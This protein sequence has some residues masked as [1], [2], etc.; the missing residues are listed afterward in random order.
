[1]DHTTGSQILQAIPQATLLNPEMM[2]TLSKHLFMNRSDNFHSPWPHWSHYT[3]ELATEPSIYRTAFNDFHGLVVSVTK[4]LVQTTLMQTTSRL[5][6]QRSRNKKGSL[7]MVRPRDVY[8]A[9][10]ALG[11]KRN[12]RERWQGV[13]RRCGLRVITSKLTSQGKH[14]KDVREVPWDEFE[15]V[16]STTAGTEVESSAE[17][18]AFKSRAAR[19]GTP[20]PMQNLTI[21]DSDDDHVVGRADITDDD[22][23]DYSES[24]DGEEDGPAER[25]ALQSE[26]TTDRDGDSPSRSAT[27]ESV[28]QLDTIEKFDWGASQ[29]EERALWKTLDMQ[30]TTEADFKSSDGELENVE[31]GIHEKITT[32]SDDWRQYHEYRAPWE[33]YDTPVSHAALLA[34]QKP[35]S[36]MP[37][38]YGSRVGSTRSASG[39]SSDPSSTTRSRRKRARSEIEVELHA[40][41]TTAYAALRRG[42]PEDIDMDSG[43]S[44]SDSTSASLGEDTIAQSIEREG[45][46]LGVDEA[47]DKMEWT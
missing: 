36:S 35:L 4:R 45:D 22:D 47:E 41:G 42:N 34:N 3:S 14:T 17:P 28:P 11:L 39:D 10:D 25:H 5:R 24:V 23:S 16:M 7:P 37:V 38:S 8:T 27:K 13:P 6:A 2:L 18:E 21:S 33:T 31:E 40:R 1:V 9:I 19:S 43:S 30:P 12:G 20:L 32:A 26:N 29:L 15:R 44:D 46:A